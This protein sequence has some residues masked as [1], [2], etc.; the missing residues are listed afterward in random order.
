V[1]PA[2]CAPPWPFLLVLVPSAPP[3]L[4]R[5]RAV[6]DTWGGPPWPG[7]GS[8]PVRSLFVL[9]VPPSPSAQR[10]LLAESRQ[11]RDIL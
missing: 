1:S 4:E 6:R 11:H 10:R 8:P 5:R 3:H 7:S 9:G 2:P